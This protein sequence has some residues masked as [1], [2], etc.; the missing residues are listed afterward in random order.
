VNRPPSRE[1]HAPQRDSGSITAF[2]VMLVLTFALCAGLAVDGGRQVGARS[3]AA[4]LAE[5]A[6]RAGA[7]ELTDIRTGTWRLDRTRARQA[8]A[9][10]LAARGETGSISVSDRRVT[11][12]VTITIN[13]SL[14]RLAGIDSRTV[15]ASRS[16][17]PFSP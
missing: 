17:E 12:V 11:V 8:A 7:Q 6:A 14:L 10:Y 15:R 16:S 2:V 9:A 13:T 3:R 5:N 4:D 1:P